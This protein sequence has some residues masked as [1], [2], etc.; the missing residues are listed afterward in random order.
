MFDDGLDL[1]GRVSRQGGHADRESG[2]SAGVTEHGDEQIRTAVD[3]TRVIGEVGRGV[4]LPVTDTM[5]RGLDP[6]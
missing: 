3:D 5:R 1:D 6:R 2:V 4:H